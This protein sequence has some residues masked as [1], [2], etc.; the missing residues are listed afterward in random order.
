MSLR[1]AAS[2]REAKLVIA[3]RVGFAARGLLYVLIGALAMQG[4]AEDA[5]GAM[6]YAGVRAGAPVLI[7]LALGFLFYGLWRLLEA[8][9]D[10]QHHGNN[11]KG[12]AL[13]VGG[14]MIGVVYLAFAYSCV[15]LL[16]FHAKMDGGH[17]AER[18]ASAALAAP[19]GRLLLFAAAIG[20]VVASC[21]QFWKAWKLG[22]LKHLVER[23]C[24]SPLVKWCGRIGLCGR[25]CVFLALGYLLWR[26]GLDLNSNEAGDSGE[27]LKAMPSTLQTWTGAA[28]VFFGLFSLIEAAFRRISDPNPAS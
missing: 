4:H 17:T 2:A 27:A 26:A 28:L 14:A 6:Q 15:R 7:A 16:S 13:R 18:G 22:F 20:L 1:T 5:R 8:W 23:A 11:A 12:V 19:G 25:G 24:R 9:S 3:A 10:T 21:V